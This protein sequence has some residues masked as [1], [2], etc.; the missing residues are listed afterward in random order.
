M[1][2]FWIASVVH[3]CLCTAALTGFLRSSMSYGATQRTCAHC[4]ALDIAIADLR[5]ITKNCACIKRLDHL[6]NAADDPPDFSV[7]DCEE[8]LQ[9]SGTGS[10]LSSPRSSY[11]CD[12]ES[13]E[14]GSALSQPLNFH[15]VASRY[16]LLC[17]GGGVIVRRWY[18]WFWRM[19]TL[20]CPYGI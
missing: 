16:S 8:G 18:W 11:V 6:F 12:F 20:I 15:I 19:Q 9:S 14:Y 1:E 2:L 17:Y 3:P 10:T 7:L 5:R 4:A 13:S